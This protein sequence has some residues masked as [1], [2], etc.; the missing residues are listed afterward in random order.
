MNIAETVLNGM[1]S[2]VS[3]AADS[4]YL[5]FYSS[6]PTLLAEC[7]MSA[8]AFGS[9][10]GGAIAA[11]AITSSDAVAS[12]DIASAKLLRSDGTTE[13]AS[14]TVGVGTGDVRL[15]RLDVNTGEPVLVRSLTLSVS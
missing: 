15:T 14:L 6:T 4:G 11:N 7:R 12:G 3:T 13:I 9:P 1:I 10:S 8:Q 5:R 2:V